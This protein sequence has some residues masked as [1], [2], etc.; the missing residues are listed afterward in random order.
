MGLKKQWQKPNDEESARWTVFQSRE[1]EALNNLVSRPRTIVK[2][3][4]IVKPSSV[5]I[6]AHWMEAYVG[7]PGKEFADVLTKATTVCSRVDM[8]VNLTSCQAKRVFSAS[9]MD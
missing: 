5:K 3:K 7:H 8:V 1:L 6:F 9:A 2:I 4:T